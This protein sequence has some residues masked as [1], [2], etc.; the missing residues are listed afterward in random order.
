M[1]VRKT[2]CVFGINEAVW[3]DGGGNRRKDGVEL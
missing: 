3:Q 1:K 2:Q